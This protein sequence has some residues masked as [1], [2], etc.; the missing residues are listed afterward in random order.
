MR[1]GTKPARE[2]DR[3]SAAPQT[4]SRVPRCRPHGVTPAIEERC[5]ERSSAIVAEIAVRD[6]ARAPRRRRS[7]RRCRVGNRAADDGAARPSTRPT[8]TP[9]ARSRCS[10]GGEGGAEVGELLDVA[11]DVGLGV[12]HRERPL[13]LVAGRHEDARGSSP[14]G[15]TRGRARGWC[16]G[17]RGSSAA[18]RAGRTRSPSRRGRPRGPGCRARPSPSRSPSASRVPMR[19]E[20]LVRVGGEHL[21]QRREPGGGDERVAVERALLRGAGADRVHDVGPAAERGAGGATADRLGP[22]RQVGL[23]AVALGRAAVRDGRAALHLVEDQ[24]RAVLVQEILEALQVAGLRAG[25]CRCSS[26]PARG[27]GTRSRR[28]A[29]RAARAAPRGR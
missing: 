20:V 27:S 29:R 16:R 15:T 1:I 10:W 7:D 26:S 23:H 14:T 3:A 25:R 2:S 4:R 12:L 18:A 9:W 28:R 6:R 22:A 11:V 5:R 24:Q 8:S 21:G 17:S 13:L 19:G